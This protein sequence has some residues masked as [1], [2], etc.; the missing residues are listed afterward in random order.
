MSHSEPTSQDRS[1]TR[2]I[3]AKMQYGKFG[4]MGV[5]KIDSQ[6]QVPWGRQSRYLNFWPKPSKNMLGTKAASPR[7][8]YKKRFSG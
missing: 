1:H 8:K 2:N 5:T 6:D 4:E 3:I 7:T